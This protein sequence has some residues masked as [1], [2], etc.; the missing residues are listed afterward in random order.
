[1]S[2]QNLA[3][4]GAHPWVAHG[5][6]DG[7]AGFATDAMQLLGP[8]YRDSGRIDGGRELPG[9]AA[10][11]RGRLPDDPVAAPPTL[12]PGA[13]AAWTF[14]GLFEPDHPEA[15][16]D[17]DLARVDEPRSR[18]LAAF[19]PRPVAVCRAGAEPPAGR[20][21][22]SP[23]GRSTPPSSPPA[24]RRASTRSA[25]TGGSL[26]FFVPDG[27]HNRHVV[28][29]DKERTLARRHGAILRSGQGMLL[30]ETTMCATCWMHGVFAALLTIGNTS[31]HR[32]FSAVARSLQHH[33]RRRPAHPRRRRAAAGVSSP[34]PRPSRSGSA[35]AAGSTASTDR[36]VTVRGHRLRR[37][38][39]DAAG[40]SRSR[41]PPCRFLVF[42]GL[43][44]GERELDHAGRVEID[45]DRCR[46]RL[47]PRP[48]LALGPALSGR[49]LPPRHRHPATRSRRSAATS[50]STPTAGRR[51]GGFV[52]LRTRADDG[53]RL[54]R[55]RRPRRSGGGRAAGGEVRGRRRR[56]GDARRRR[57]ATGPTSPAASGSAAAPRS[58]RLDTLLPWLA[59]NAMM[60]LT[61]PARPRAVGRR[62]LG[63]PRRLPGAGRVPARARA[64]RAGEGHPAHRLRR[65]RAR[66]AATGRSG[67]CSSPTPRSATGTATATSSS[68][69]S[70]RSAT[71]SRRPT[72]SPSSTS[73]SPGGATRTSRQRAQRDP[74]S[75]HVDEAPRHRAR[76]LHPRH[77]PHPL[78]RGRL[79]RLAAAGR[80]ADARLDGVELDGGAALPAARPLR[81]GRSPGP[82]GPTRRRTSPGSRRRCA[83]TSTATSSA[84]APSPAT[85]SSTRPA[86][87]PSCCCTRRDTRTGLRYSLLPMTRSIIGGLFTRRAG[88]ASPRP[89]PRAPALPRRR[90]ADGPAGR[91]PRRPRAHLPPRRSRPPSSGARSASCTSTPTCATARRWRS[92]ARPTALW[93]ALQVVEP[94]QRRRRR[95]QRDAA[96]AQRLLQQQR[97]R[98]PRPLPRQR[99]VAAGARRHRRRRRR[100]ADLLERPGALHQPAGLPGAGHPAVVRGA[101]RGAGAAA[102][103]SARSRWR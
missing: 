52:A 16:G 85:R 74:V 7:A 41:A 77:P 65:S 10:A 53:A 34:S 56:G 96:P 13:A 97:R 90:A 2:R 45:A 3:Q 66:P 25:A 88:A 87:S 64:R 32:L 40:A 78:R 86:P 54:R 68:G 4:G 8:A 93:E 37:R 95:R 80:P 50:S 58:R 81:R 46:D 38:P 55:R 24:T 30:D 28:L 26:S 83:P 20:G 98:L 92:S 23:A 62:R 42:G 63:H 51:G 31:F 15:S 82:A 1:M 60:H 18:P 36:T 44:L 73:R 39:G 27:A 5:C 43:V 48:R 79:E 49:R 29:R 75:A 17:A 76:A 19:A 94:D 72:T 91:L 103:D 33:P 89:D 59:Q 69:R 47:P 102:R 71:T 70:R 21:A 100:L 61:V 35:T 6:L 12:A 101:G 9:A 67:S 57:R 14:F 99:R 84:T 11:A 22:A